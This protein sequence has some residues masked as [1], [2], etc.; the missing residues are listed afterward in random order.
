LNYRRLLHGTGA[1]LPLHYTVTVPYHL[2]GLLYHKRSWA[3]PFLLQ[4]DTVPLLQH[5]RVKA[6]LL[7]LR[8]RAAPPLLCNE[9]RGPAPH[10]KRGG[11]RWG[12]IYLLVTVDIMT[13]L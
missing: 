1:S 13:P 5:G 4:S 6:G 2:P 12:T 10:R 7:F 3:V 11:K 8:R 9:G